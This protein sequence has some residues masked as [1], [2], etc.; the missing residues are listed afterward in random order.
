MLYTPLSLSV[1]EIKMEGIVATGG[2][3]YLW[4][5]LCTLC[6]HTVSCQ[7]RVSHCRRF[8]SLFSEFVYLFL[9]YLK[10][11]RK[12]ND[13]SFFV[14]F[15]PVLRSRTMSNFEYKLVW[16]VACCAHVCRWGCLKLSKWD[17]GYVR[18]CVAS[19]PVGEFMYLVC[20]NNVMPDESYCRWSSSFLLCSC[21]VF[22]SAINSSFFSPSL[23]VSAP[24]ENAACQQFVCVN[25]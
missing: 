3:P 10:K 12:R 20:T 11:K 18:H 8:S 25:M 22:L 16:Y 17:R 4:W 15:Q 7:V 21:D 6:W 1:S 5:C 19:I 2:R 23:F 14:I 9:F 13:S 24:L